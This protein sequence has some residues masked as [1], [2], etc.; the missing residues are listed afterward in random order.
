MY[1]LKEK[2]IDPTRGADP[3]GRGLKGGLE[4]LA[5]GVVGKNGG[6]DCECFRVPTQDRRSYSSSIQ[7]TI[8][9]MM[10]IKIII[11]END[12]ALN[13]PAGTL[14]RWNGWNGSRA[15][16]LL[17]CRCEDKSQFERCVGKFWMDGWIRE[18]DT[19]VFFFTFKKGVSVCVGECGWVGVG[20]LKDESR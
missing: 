7:S 16:L 13:R 15:G 19:G 3:E 8:C 4:R 11:I 6:G 17:N 5:V 12:N 1:D 14:L 20:G 18:G 10:I 2:K 9:A